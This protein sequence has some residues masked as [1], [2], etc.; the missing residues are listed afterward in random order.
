MKTLTAA[1]GGDAVSNDD[2]V[3]LSL[4]E[5]VAQHCQ[6][7]DGL[8]ERVEHLLVLVEQRLQLFRTSHR[9]YT[10]I[11]I[12][13]SHQSINQSSFINGKPTIHKI[14]YTVSQKNDNDVAHYNFNAH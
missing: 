13:P 8:D 1:G 4:V 11:N 12:S 6:L 3:Y 5:V 7:L 14:M 9:P 2:D 10:A